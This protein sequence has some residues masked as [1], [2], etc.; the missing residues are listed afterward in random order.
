MSRSRVCFVVAL[1]AVFGLAAH[2]ASA[3]IVTVSLD[4]IFFGSA[5][6]PGVDSTTTVSATTTE[7]KPWAM[8]TFT[9]VSGGVQMVL[10]GANLDQHNNAAGS[11]SGSGYQHL[12]NGMTNSTHTQVT[13]GTAANSQGWFFNVANVSVSSLTFTFQS[14]VVDPH[15]TGFA[16]PRIVTGANFF[17]TTGG[18]GPKSGLYDINVQFAEGDASSEF[19]YGDSVTYLITGGGI[20]AADFGTLSSASDGSTTQYTSAAWIENGNNGWI[21]AKTFTRT[22][23]DQAI[24]PEPSTLVVAAVGALGFIGYGLRRRTKLRS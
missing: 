19:Q 6:I 14:E 2:N 22:I 15:Q 5:E 20:T 17:N 3:D 9:D 21:A 7:S 4:T 23:S 13:S 24:S 10:S 1:I 11:G 8:A 18:M 16:T 12:G